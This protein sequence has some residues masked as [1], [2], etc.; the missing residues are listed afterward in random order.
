M[1]TTVEIS[2]TLLDDAKRLATRE[3]TTLR[4]LIEDGLRRVLG[5]RKAKRSRFKL[6][7][8]SCGGRGLT[9]EFREAGWEKIRDEIYDGHGA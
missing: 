4:Q 7:D 8:A 6:R 5:E 1:K 3:G 9:P 2:D